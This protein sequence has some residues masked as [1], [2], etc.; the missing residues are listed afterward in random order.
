MSAL[1]AKSLKEYEKE[2]RDFIV[3]KKK[4]GV[5]IKVKVFNKFVEGQ[6]SDKRPIP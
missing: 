1:P 4:I 6:K 5:Q 3:M 2:N